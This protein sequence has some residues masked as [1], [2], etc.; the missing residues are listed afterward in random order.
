MRKTTEHDFNSHG[1]LRKRGSTKSLDNGRISVLS[2]GM[3]LTKQRKSEIC[4]ANNSL[5]SSI[6]LYRSP[7]VDLTRFSEWSRLRQSDRLRV[8][9]EER[10]SLK[11]W[12]RFA[13]LAIKSNP[14]SRLGE[15]LLT[16]LLL[17]RAKIT[18][19]RRELWN[20]SKLSPLVGRADQNFMQRHRNHP[21]C[22]LPLNRQMPK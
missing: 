14:T 21:L 10:W 16:C 13:E 22:G 4:H 5:P 8:N 18:I 15:C 1:Q 19:R 6:F 20:P 3:L 12:V 2:S 11:M 17:C 9:C 7:H